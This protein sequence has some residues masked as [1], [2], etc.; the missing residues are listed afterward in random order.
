MRVYPQISWS[1]DDIELPETAVV[2]LSLIFNELSTNA[3]KYG[4][5]AVEGGAVSITSTL[6]NGA[7]SKNAIQIVWKEV[8]GGI[9]DAEPTWIGFGTQLV[10]LSIK[11][12]LKGTIERDWEK[13]GM[14]C[15]LR[16][17][18]PELRGQAD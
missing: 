16:F 11:E 18:C 7:D 17:P 9:V 12:T 8:G 10:D 3:M 14:T 4:A 15:V 13:D 1:G 2:A 5:L 6:V